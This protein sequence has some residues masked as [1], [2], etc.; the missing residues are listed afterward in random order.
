VRFGTQTRRFGAH[1]IERGTVTV[2][3]RRTR[4]AV[5]AVVCMLASLGLS[6]PARADNPAPP[7][8]GVQIT[9]PPGDQSLPGMSAPDNLDI[10]AVFFRND[11]A[12]GGGVNVNIQVTN[13]TDTVP[14]GA[15][16]ASWQ[17]G[18]TYAGTDYFLVASVDAS[19]TWR[20]S[21]GHFDKTQMQNLI[22]GDNESGKTFMGPNGVIQ[23]RVPP[24]SGGAADKNLTATNAYSGATFDFVAE[25][26][27]LIADSAPD[28]GNGKDYTATACAPGT[29]MPAFLPT[30]PGGPPGP[31]AKSASTLKLKVLTKSA[32]RKKAKK[33]KKIKLKLRSS[34]A[35][36]GLRAALFTG[37]VG[38]PKVFA[39]GSLKAIKKGKGTLKIKVRRKL[40]K[41]SYSL[42]IAGTGADGSPGTLLVKFKIK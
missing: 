34:E 33:G 22:D 37:T 16:N 40:K 2:A 25:R 6:A 35:I 30:S 13:L 4:Y 42:L 8:T 18:W 32:K 15:T 38:K 21:R 17:V 7:C 11:I 26:L 31:A 27:S 23:I 41:G 10:T 29:D 5:V 14:S 3:T 9:D 1:P 12:T 19:G 24:G 36:K 39:T 20:Y 28:S